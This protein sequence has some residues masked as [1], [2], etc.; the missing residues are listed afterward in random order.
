MIIGG[1][2]HRLHWLGRLPLLR[3]QSHRPSSPPRWLAGKNLNI[4]SV[5]PTLR[6]PCDWSG[7]C[8]Q[9]IEG[10]AGNIH[11]DSIAGLELAKET[12]KEVVVWPMINPKLFT[13]SRA[14]PKV[15]I[16]VMIIGPSHPRT[17]PPCAFFKVWCVRHILM[18]HGNRTQC[19]RTN[20][21]YTT[22]SAGFVL[23]YVVAKPKHTNVKER[24][25]LRLA[26]CAHSFHL[27]SSQPNNTGCCLSSISESV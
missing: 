21:Y 11:W 8:S 16:V 15:T 22:N 3:V 17:P 20:A 6:A 14:P 9:I 12:I 10:A 4:T 2:T 7:G 27:L 5:A 18:N 25:R 24:V 13:G 26:L 23:L 1:S 19:T